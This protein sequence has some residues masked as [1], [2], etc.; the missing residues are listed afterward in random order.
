MY[1][2]IN[3]NKF[4]KRWSLL[5]R[6]V[7]IFFIQSLRNFYTNT[8]DYLPAYSHP[9]RY[10]GSYSEVSQISWL[11]LR[12]KIF[13]PHRSMDRSITIV[14]NLQQIFEYYCLIFKELKKKESPSHDVTAKKK[15]H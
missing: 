12:I 11:A 8:E 6:H 5:S 10:A 1:F 4:F 13:H 7:S 15:K 9:S 3:Y 14:R 2:S